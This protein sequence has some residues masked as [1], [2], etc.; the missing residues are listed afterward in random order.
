[1]LPDFES[2]LRALAEVIVRVGL[3]L[4]PGQRLL[5]TEPYELQG[6]AR[7]TEIMVAA[8]QTAARESGGRQSLSPDI[9]WGDGP[10]LR[11][12]AAQADWSGYT[13]LVAA[14]AA[15]MQTAIDHGDALLFLQGS[16]PHL[17]AGVPADRVNELR[18]LGWEHF[19]P[20]AQQLLAGATNWTAVPAP[21]PGWADQVYADLPADQR[22]PALWELVLTSCRVGPL[23]PG[24]SGGTSQPTP[25]RHAAASLQDWGTHL[26]ALETLRTRLNQQRL[27]SLHYVGPGTD[28]RVTL[29][30]EHRWAS[31]GLQT[32][33]GL[34]FVANLPTEEV[35]TLPHRDSAAGTVSVARPVNYGG[36]TIEGIVLEFRRGRVVRSTARTNSVLLAQL[37]AEDEGASRL[38]EVALVLQEA[39]PARAGRNFHHPLLDENAS[40]HIALGDAYGMCLSA[41]NAAAQNR[42]SIHLDL[43]I[44][45]TVAWP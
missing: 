20:I 30:P 45:A 29:P 7:S 37:L 12:Y 3:N 25:G 26:A 6:V 36:A 23:P 19:G 5:I 15:V 28:L 32:T 18:R 27:T 8:V 10:R 34:P 35:F 24:E 4:Q 9:I 11:E 2:R 14:N 33:S 16:Q 21:S 31:A 39:S 42:S 17:M 41:P 40:S 38:G 13:R 1:M 44:A 43:P 22:L